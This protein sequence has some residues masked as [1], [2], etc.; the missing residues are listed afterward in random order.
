MEYDHRDF[1]PPWGH[2]LF[3]DEAEKPAMPVCLDCNRGALPSWLTRMVD[4]GN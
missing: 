3:D 2:G 4:K 1:I